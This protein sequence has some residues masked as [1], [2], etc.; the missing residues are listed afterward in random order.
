MKLWKQSVYDT[1]HI[2]ASSFASN[3]AFIHLILIVGKLLQKEPFI[4]AIFL[5]F[6]FD[7][8]TIGKTLR[9][10][11]QFPTVFLA[12]YQIELLCMVALCL[13]LL[14]SS[15]ALALHLRP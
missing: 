5:C 4:L 7:V 11:M 13:R 12:Q 15:R 6:I 1:F 9:L 3:L 10:D 8:H 2:A 14:R